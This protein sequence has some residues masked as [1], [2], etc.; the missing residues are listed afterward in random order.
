MEPWGELGAGSQSAQVLEGP[1]EGVLSDVIR[2]VVIPAE[3]IRESVH[4]PEMARHESVEGF[5]V[6]VLRP[7]HEPGLTD[8]ISTALAS[9]AHQRTLRLLHRAVTLPR[10]RVCTPTY[11]YLANAGSG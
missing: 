3:A 1:H 4:S 7:R 5:R 8:S 11:Y 10:L 6:A 2:V 9:P